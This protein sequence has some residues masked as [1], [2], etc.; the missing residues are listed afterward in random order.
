MPLT[1]L[2]QCGSRKGFVS[3]RVSSPISPDCA[4]S[5]ALAVWIL[6]RDLADTWAHGYVPHETFVKKRT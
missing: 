4:R 5:R 1:F 2:R 6:A 3:S